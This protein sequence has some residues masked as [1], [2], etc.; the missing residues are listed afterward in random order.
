MHLI[1]TFQEPIQLNGLLVLYDTRN[2]YC[3]LILSITE[4]KN[5]LN[6]LIILQ[7]DHGSAVSA[8]VV[9]VWLY[10]PGLLER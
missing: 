1:N 4:T 6:L 5:L 3:L 7:G 9:F 8:R 10:F 2:K